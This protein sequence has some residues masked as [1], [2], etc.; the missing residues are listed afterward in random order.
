MPVFALKALRR[1]VQWFQLNLLSKV[2]YVC[3]AYNLHF[4]T[5]VHIMI[6]T[7]FFLSLEV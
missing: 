3:N 1:W 7:V 4:L 2:S 6:A 5:I